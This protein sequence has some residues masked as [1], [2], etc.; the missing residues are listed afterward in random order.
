[1]LFIGTEK[2]LEGN[3]SLFYVA[4]YLLSLLFLS[5]SHLH[6]KY[7]AT[8]AMIEIIRFDMLFIGTPPFCCQI[9]SDNKNILS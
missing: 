3:L 8:F 4:D 1:M 5:S 7:A 9:G 6:I 2:D